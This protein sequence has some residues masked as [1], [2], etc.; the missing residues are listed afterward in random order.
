MQ[1]RGGVS[2]ERTGFVWELG[3]L[4][5]H[6]VTCR[7][8]TAQHG[9]F[10]NHN[11]PLSLSDFHQP[12]VCWRAPPQFASLLILLKQQSRFSSPFQPTCFIVRTIDTQ[13]CLLYAPRL[14]VLLGYLLATRDCS[15]CF[16]LV[17]KD[18]IGFNCPCL[19]AT[20]H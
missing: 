16:L 12:L 13:D 1:P 8:H 2:G 11:I 3:P 4:E 5:G 14:R 6:S 20:D 19:I 18:N 9:F 15:S 7:S 17:S 10:V